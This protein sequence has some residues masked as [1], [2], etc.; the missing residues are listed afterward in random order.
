MLH[1]TTFQLLGLPKNINLVWVQFL[2]KS[3]QN[4]SPG[5][6]GVRAELSDGK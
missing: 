2:F 4:S 6:G 1:D 3:F 5:R